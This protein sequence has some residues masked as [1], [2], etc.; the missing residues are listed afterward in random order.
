[1][2]VHVYK[3]K[4]D[5]VINWCHEH[6]KDTVRVYGPTLAPLHRVSY[7]KMGAFFVVFYFSEDLDYIHFLLKWS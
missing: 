5:P 6:F 2:N 3:G 4:I 7:D 1:M